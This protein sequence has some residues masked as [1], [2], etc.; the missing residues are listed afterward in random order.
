VSKQ[1]PLST[2]QFLEIIKLDTGGCYDDSPE[3]SENY[4]D[5]S[6]HWFGEH[7]REAV[8]ILKSK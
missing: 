6:E 3:Y 7:I 5:K 4:N 8:R 1:K 2:E